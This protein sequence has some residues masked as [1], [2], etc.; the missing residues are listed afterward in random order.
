MK[1]AS[2]QIT[3]RLLP[4]EKIA[5]KGAAD[6]IKAHP[7]LVYF[8]PNL[9]RAARALLGNMSR[10]DLATHTGV[11]RQTIRNFEDQTHEVSPK[12][13]I[14]IEDYFSREGITFTTG[15]NR[16]SLHYHGSRDQKIRAVKV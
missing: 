9:C 6:K 4:L 12:T 3:D 8:S 13:L 14:K 10:E 11:S 1:K 2:A 5:I 15:E 7:Q 16:E